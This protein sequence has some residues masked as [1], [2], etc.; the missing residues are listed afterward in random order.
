[1]HQHLTRP[2]RRKPL[3]GFTLIELLVV[4]SIIALLIALLL[5]ALKSARQVARSMACMSNQRQLGLALI[6]YT[7]EN[8]NV[9]PRGQNG[10]GGPTGAKPGWWDATED[11]VNA[12]DSRDAAVYRCP[13]A[14]RPDGGRHFGSNPGVMRGI[15]SAQYPSADNLDYDRIG[16]FSEV[17]MIMDGA[18]WFSTPSSKDTQQWL[19]GLDT[20]AVWGTSFNSSSAT[21]DDPIRTGMNM[22]QV[23]TPA[24]DHPRWR[25][26]GASGLDG[27]LVANLLWADGHVESREE[28]TVLNRHLRPDTASSQAGN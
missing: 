23:S 8:D 5:P 7:Q 15:S 22:D 4:I 26:A 19:K 12:D 6:L 13:N 3:H 21:L 17:V 10:G 20:G 24:K 18:Q 1:M 14:T 2:A 27:R 11:F 9:L 28:G 16:R 25:E